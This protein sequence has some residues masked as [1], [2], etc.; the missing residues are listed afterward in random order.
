MDHAIIQ[1]VVM[2]VKLNR[3]KFLG[4]LWLIRFPMATW[5]TIV[6]EVK[7]SVR[8][9]GKCTTETMKALFTFVRESV[10]ANA[11]NIT[12]PKPQGYR[13]PPE[14]ESDDGKEISLGEAIVWMWSLDDIS[15]EIEMLRR[16]DYT[17]LQI[18]YPE[19]S[20]GEVDDAARNKDEEG[21]G[22]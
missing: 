5:T 20:D 9:K 19:E 21:A 10:S 15:E 14:D 3:I 13:P 12:V 16:Q 8:S 22:R 7:E 18:D 2:M 1:I 6:S 11:A 4:V 17:T